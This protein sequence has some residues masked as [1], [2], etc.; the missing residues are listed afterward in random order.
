[1]SRLQLESSVKTKTADRTPEQI[2]NHYRIEQELANRLRH[3]PK[4]ERGHL[5][6]E[7]YDELFLRVPDHPQNFQR[8]SVETQRDEVRRQMPMIRRFL[9]PG[10]T[11][12]EIGVGDCAIAIAAA[13]IAKQV[14][15]VDVSSEISARVD[16]PAN[17]TF[18]LSDGTSID[19]PENSVDVAYSNQLMEHLHPDDAMDQLR[20]IY[21]ALRPG[22]VYIC[23]TPN[24]L[25]GPHDISRHFDQTPTGFHLREYTATELKDLFRKVGFS[26]VHCYVGGRNLLAPIPIGAATTI[27]RVISIL[28]G[29]L[30]RPIVRFAPVRLFLDFRIIGR[31]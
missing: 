2:L 27:E 12:L 20:N 24:R 7:V 6:N 15:A 13:E 31:K 14:Y 4:S 18:V 1:M 5:Y 22:G 30:R 25:S 9:K 3:A 26:A 11:Y 29:W 8:E 28:P 23:I 10:D 21:R 16:A 17:F 19:C